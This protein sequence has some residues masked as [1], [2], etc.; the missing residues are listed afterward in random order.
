MN[1]PPCPI[2]V[3]RLEKIERRI[4][5]LVLGPGIWARW[6][7]WRKKR[8]R[9]TNARRKGTRMGA[10]VQGAIVPA[11]VMGIRNAVDETRKMTVP[12]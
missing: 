10:D 11:K 9:P 3:V 7:W 8:T 6:R 4:R 5:G 12:M 1:V 2:A